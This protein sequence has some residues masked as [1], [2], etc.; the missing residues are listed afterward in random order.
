MKRHQNLALCIKHLALK[1]TLEVAFCFLAA[2]AHVAN[3]AGFAVL[4]VLHHRGDSG[5]Q[6]LRCAA[7]TNLEMI[8]DDFGAACTQHPEKSITSLIAPRGVDRGDIV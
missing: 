6:N 7:A 2:W 8:R 5:V 4:G 3:G 1:A